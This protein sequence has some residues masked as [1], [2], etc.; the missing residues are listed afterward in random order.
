MKIFPFIYYYF[1]LGSCEVCNANNAKYTCPRCEVKTC[2]IDCVRIHKAELACSGTRDK[3]VYK[4]LSKFSNLD[5]LS[6]L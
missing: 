6:G 1:R 4:P 2:S 5:L 3:T